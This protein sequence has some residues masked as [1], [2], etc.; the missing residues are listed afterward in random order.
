MINDLQKE[1]YPGKRNLFLEKVS[2]HA[3]NTEPDIEIVKKLLS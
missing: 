3:D 1:S 2:V